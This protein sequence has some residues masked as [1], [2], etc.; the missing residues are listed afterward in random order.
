V[1]GL[2]GNGPDAEN[3]QRIRRLHQEGL[4]LRG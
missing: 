4:E 2:A 3:M 1:P